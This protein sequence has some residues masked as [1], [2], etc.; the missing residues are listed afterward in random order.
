MLQ[1][2]ERNFMKLIIGLG[3]PGRKYRRTR[4]NVGY[5]FVDEV[6]KAFNS[7]FKLNKS[8]KSEICEIN[9][10]GEKVILIKPQTYMNNS[11]EA[12]V[13]IKKYYN[14]EL[15]DIIVIYDDLD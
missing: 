1:T 7:K 11:G 14:I 8:M 10:F 12:V 4:H 2:I 15:E 6:A 13:L 9:I 5:M 3:N